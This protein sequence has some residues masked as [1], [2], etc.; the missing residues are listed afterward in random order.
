MRNHLKNVDFRIIVVEQTDGHVFNKG[1]LFN[2]GYQLAKFD[3]DYICLHDVDQIPISKEN[4][5]SFVEFPTHLCTASSQFDFK[6]A[7]GSMVGG[8]LLLQTVHFEV[9][10]V[11]YNDYYSRNSTD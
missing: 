4:K 2:I 3:Y 6:M 8:A 10:N 5:Y 7:Y 1:A 9:C 11:F